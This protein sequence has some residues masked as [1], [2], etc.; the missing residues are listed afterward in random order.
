MIC[1]RMK[2]D[3]AVG[4]IG[5]YDYAIV[6]EFS[7]KFFKEQNNLSEINWDECVEARFFSEEK[8]LYFYIYFFNHLL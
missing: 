8:E 2:F 6:F 5:E 3:E 7:R 4:R 1:E